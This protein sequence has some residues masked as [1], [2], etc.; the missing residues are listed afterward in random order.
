MSQILSPKT[1]E[2]EGRYQLKHFYNLSEYVVKT[3]L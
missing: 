2:N 1:I 3:L